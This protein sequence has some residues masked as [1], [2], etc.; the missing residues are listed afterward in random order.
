MP[1]T[2]NQVIIPNEGMPKSH[3]N[4]LHHLYLEYDADESASW[5]P[6]RYQSLHLHQHT[7][8]ENHIAAMPER[9]IG[10]QELLPHPECVQV[11]IEREFHAFVSYS[12]LLSL[13]SLLH[14]FPMVVQLSA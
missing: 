7:S 8:I 9:T 11:S 4:I 3:P 2:L 1:L 10:I 13:H 5:I 14:L 6:H 12:L